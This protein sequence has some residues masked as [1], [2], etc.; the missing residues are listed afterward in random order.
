[1]EL[2]Y[3]VDPSGHAVGLVQLQTVVVRLDEAVHVWLIMTP[4]AI[5]GYLQSL[6]GVHVELEKIG[7]MIAH[8]LHYW[9]LIVLEAGAF[10]GA[11]AGRSAIA[12][13]QAVDL[14][15]L[16]FGSSAALELSSLRKADN[17]VYLHNIRIQMEF[18]QFVRLIAEAGA[19]ATLQTTAKRT[20]RGCTGSQFATAHLLI[21]M[22]LLAVVV[23]GGIALHLVHQ[24]P[25]DAVRN[26][27]FQLSARLQQMQMSLWLHTQHM[28]DQI[29]R[30]LVVTHCLVIAHNTLH[31]I[32]GG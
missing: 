28:I 26:E 27:L 20:L 32:Q 21:E 25:L 13:A 30:I 14:R 5:V 17:I 3:I 1:M 9:M 18:L 15:P 11:E 6:C 8:F 31:E 16:Q 19:A 4:N 2:T 7:Q 29:Q 24:S 23:I 12:A 10:A 22:I